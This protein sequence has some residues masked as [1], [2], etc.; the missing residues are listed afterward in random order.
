LLVDPTTNPGRWTAEE[1]EQVERHPQASYEA[2]L[3]CGLS[4]GQLMMAYQ[5]HERIDGGGYPVG[6]M[7]DEIHPWAKIVAIA[8]R[9]DALSTGR[10]YRRG[11]ELPQAI[12]QLELEAQGGLDAEMTQCWIKSLRSN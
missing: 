12:A 7:D 2:L 4:R 11:L 3:P 10:A 6:V 5:H 8:D 9:F 1:R